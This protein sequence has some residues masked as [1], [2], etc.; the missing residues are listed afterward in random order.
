MARVLSMLM[1]RQSSRGSAG[2]SSG[3][4]GASIACVSSAA[5]GPEGFLPSGPGP[6]LRLALRVDPV[7]ADGRAVCGDTC[8]HRQVPMTGRTRPQEA[9]VWPPGRSPRPKR[10]GR[11]VPAV[12]STNAALARIRGSPP[13]TC[14]ENRE[15]QRGPARRPA[16]SRRTCR[17][18]RRRSGSTENRRCP[19]VCR[20]CSLTH[21]RGAA[22]PRR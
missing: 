2:G 6:A 18:P 11:P 19:G 21:R 16:C 20:G 1:S 14:S 8:G 7:A 17:R 9:P 4:R 15:S 12:A 13:G 22:A 5:A 10:P 3:R